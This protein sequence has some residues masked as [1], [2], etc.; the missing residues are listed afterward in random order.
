[1]VVKSHNW[2]ELLLECMESTN[3]CCLSTVDQR[4]GVWANPVYFAWD[5]KF[6]LYF[7]SMLHSRHMQNISHN[8]QVAVAIYKT[9]QKGDVV[10]I[11]LEGD[12]VILKDDKDKRNA[13][14]VYYGRKGSLEQNEPFIDNPKWLFVKIT[15]KDIYYFNS[16]LFGEER[17][18]V[19]SQSL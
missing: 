14:Q 18:K 16:K 2:K 10:G 9:E 11:Q 3:Y 13:N 5:E 15:P 7:I 6:N 12:A 4:S 8:S 17:Q 1:M 19:P